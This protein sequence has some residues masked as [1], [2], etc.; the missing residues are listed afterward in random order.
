MHWHYVCDLPDCREIFDFLHCP[1]DQATLK[2]Y[3]RFNAFLSN[4]KNWARD[5]AEDKKLKNSKNEDV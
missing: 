5:K 2:Y 4:P 1:I 3:D